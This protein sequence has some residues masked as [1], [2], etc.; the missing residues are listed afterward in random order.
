MKSRRRK[1]KKCCKCKCKTCT[2]KKCP[3][4]KRSRRHRMKGGYSQFL[5]NVPYSASYSTG[6]H[7]SPS[8][9]ALANPV[10]HQRFVNCP[11]K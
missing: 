7:I 10:P 1:S 2:C 8:D 5:S 6:G 4:K 11:G 9:L 3:T